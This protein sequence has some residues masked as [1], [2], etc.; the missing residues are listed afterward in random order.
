MATTI[1]KAPRQIDGLLI[2]DGG[3]SAND[4]IEVN[5]IAA[6]GGSGGATAGTLDVDVRRYNGDAVTAAV[7]LLIVA[8]DSAYA[9]AYDSNANVTFNTASAGT[10]VASGN[11]WALVET[12]ASGNFTCA[13]ANAS[14]ETVYFAGKTAVGVDTLA[15]GALVV[16]SV[17]D[18]ATWAA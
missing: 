11:G 15:N 17:S 18:S 14:D 4:F 7:T 3:L 5:A 8:S 12:D 1:E 10:L 13:T 6:A 9:G 2:K 16:R